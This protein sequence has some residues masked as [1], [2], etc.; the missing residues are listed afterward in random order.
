M[1]PEQEAATTQDL[2]G[3]VSRFRRHV[4]IGL[5]IIFVML[6]LAYG[7]TKMM[8]PRY[9]AA[10]QLSYAPQQALSRDGQAAP[11]QQMSDS[12]RDA[13]VESQLQIA[14]SLPVAIQ[15]LKNPQVANDPHIRSRAKAFDPT[16]K[17]SDALAASLLA[18]VT[19]ARLGTTPFFTIGYSDTDPLAAA[20]I[21]NAVAAAY[22]VVQAEQ[23]LGQ[24][25]AT[26][27]QLKAQV[28]KLR[29]QA[30]QADAAVAAYRLKHNILTDPNASM[31]DNEMSNIGVQLSDARGAAAQ[32]QSRSAVSGST[33]ISGGVDTT[34]L[35]TLREQ[36]AEASRDLAGLASRYGDRNPQVID[37]R[38]K[39]ADLDD[40]LAKEMASMSRSAR[41]ESNAAAARSASL[42]SSLAQAQAKLAGTVNAG[43]Q[44]AELQRRADNAHTLYTNLL[45]ASGQQN[46]NAAMIQ[47]DA[48][49]VTPAVAPLAPSSPK[50]LINLLVGFIA[51]LAIA[52]AVAYLR[53]RWSQTINTIE[54]V[55]RLLGVEFLTTI[56]TLQSA[57]D[58]PKTRDPAEAVILHPLSSYAEAFRSLAQT[59]VF[60]ARKSEAPGGRVIGVGSALPREGKTTTT[61]SIAR[62]LAMGATKVVL[63]DADLRRRSVTET[64][65][66]STQKGW[67]DVLNGTATLS[68]VMIEDQ[69]GAI[70]LPLAPGSERAQR[71]F[72]G[73][74]FEKMLTHL[75]EHFE[76]VVVD[77]AP[78]L[79]LVDTRAMMPHLD[80][81]VLLAHW[82][83]TPVKAIRA[84]LHQ[85]DTI[86]AAVAGVAMTMV[87]LKTQ[88]QSGYG[89]ASYY[90]SEMKDY[91]V[92]S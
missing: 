83:T 85:L 77:T 4:P 69:T 57:I 34:A 74:A 68:E 75:R 46:A 63:I 64:L 7:G 36:R 27:N 56:P 37:A 33:V 90:Y 91:Y 21:A 49:L 72:D 87:N 76:V 92:S 86:G 41:A 66:P 67:I 80:S 88:A 20:R 40:A 9:S 84:A 58:K 31:P 42:Q 55:Q 11:P 82:R 18:S 59:L 17:S 81:F 70:V 50:M 30:E 22:L 2:A 65:A 15:A 54:D 51:G 10:A 24:G 47:P 43:V 8:T 78:V 44:L 32:A 71:V 16:G 25:S 38:Q 61:I 52:I 39:V 35:A 62:V 48:Q 45:T 26:S 3:I 29:A 13:A 89:D 60:D 28:D 12:A 79:A 1:N 5:A 53:E 73:D 23:K 19:T 6:L 14:M